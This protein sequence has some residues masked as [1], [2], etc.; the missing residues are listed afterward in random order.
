MPIYTP[1]LQSGFLPQDGA[2][3]YRVV[4]AYKDLNGNLIQG[5]PSQR[6]VVGNPM[7]EL[8]IRDYTRLLSTLWAAKYP[9]NRSKNQRQEL[10]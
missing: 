5:A 7:I 3:A 8:L 10:C 9:P 4:W 2:V 6:A 1:N